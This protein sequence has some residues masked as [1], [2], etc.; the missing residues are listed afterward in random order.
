MDATIPTVGPPAVRERLPPGTVIGRYVIVAPI[1]AGG[2]GE[3][4]AAFDPELDRKVA[5]KLVRPDTSDMVDITEARARMQREA[6]AMA[7]LAHP[8]VVAV[9]D[10]GTFGDD[11]FVAMELIEGATLK[12]WL[13]ETHRSWREI[14]DVFVQAARGLAAAHA[15]GMVHRDFKP[16]N[17]M[18]GRDGRVRVLDFGLAR[19]A[20]SDEP[21]RPLDDTALSHSPLGATLTEPGTL[22]GTPAYMSP[23]QHLRQSTDARSDQFSFCV[24]LHEGLYGARP[25]DGDT[26]AELGIAVIQGKPAEPP[27]N[28][29]VPAWL[30]DVIVRGL[31]TDPAARFPAMDAV[32]AALLADPAVRRRRIALAVGVPLVLVGAVAAG[33]A[34][35]HSSR[36]SSLVA[37]GPENLDFEQGALGQ[38]PKGWITAGEP[39]LFPIDV[40]D[41]GCLVGHCARIHA[42]G[43]LGDDNFGNLM[44][45]IDAARYRGKRVRF[46]I[47]Y[48]L[49][50]APEAFA[51]MRVDRPD[52]KMGF[53]YSTE[54]EPA[55]TG[56]WT[57]REIVGDVAADALAINIG[58]VQFQHGTTL[59]DSASFEIVPDATPL[60]TDRFV[61]APE[62][63]DFEAGEPGQPPP[64]W[65]VLPQKGGG[66]VISTDAPHGGAHCVRVP[67]AGPAPALLQR[68]DARP[69]RGKHLRIMAY[70]RDVRDSM[71]DLGVETADDTIV[72][73]EAAP[74]T[75]SP[76]EWRAHVL[77]VAVP[78]DARVLQ[79][80]IYA[81][82]HTTIFVDDLTL[83]AP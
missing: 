65:L 20:H 62:D 58:V 61:H 68:L 23:E 66:A 6:Q 25:F 4:Y 1:G 64:G 30:H 71:M 19:G 13:A 40:V 31:A 32:I 43:A 35:S 77:D 49:D 83:T 52:Q 21:V 70:A 67:G 18:I 16:E 2:V 7:K 59:V 74:A 47:S 46:R 22:L 72:V 12:R 69:W 82:A 8:N 78:A 28:T 39:R 5:I 26:I 36:P 33:H 76:G 44:Q 45:T 29:K 24:A 57:T 60:T 51:W 37:A 9:H 81:D 14:R 38:P 42:Q 75:G 73:E 56:G 15:A 10:V 54:Y 55:N 3:V 48:R 50:G 53:D 27:K 11:L 17:V 79:L 34:L 41:Q 63:L 80:A